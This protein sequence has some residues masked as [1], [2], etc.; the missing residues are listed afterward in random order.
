MIKNK[1]SNKKLPLIKRRYMV[2]FI[3]LF[4]WDIRIEEIRKANR[5]GGEK[6]GKRI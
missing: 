4:T 3:M 5:Y 2:L 6:G 1:K